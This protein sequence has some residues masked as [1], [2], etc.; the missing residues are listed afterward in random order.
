[1]M[2][3]PTLAEL[4][5][6]S[7]WTRGLKADRKLERFHAEL[8]KYWD[9]SRGVAIVPKDNHEWLRKS[10]GHPAARVRRMMDA[11]GVMAEYRG[12][13]WRFVKVGGE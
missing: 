12:R 1:M 2:K 7:P 4:E 8:V 6:V 3:C 11:C 9:E 5:A 13:F 10:N